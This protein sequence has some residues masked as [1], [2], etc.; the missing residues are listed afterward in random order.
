MA[1]AQ[2]SFDRL[3]PLF[4]LNLTFGGGD[5]LLTDVPATD[6]A[7]ET[8]EREEFVDERLL[9]VLLWFSGN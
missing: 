4:Q 6:P 9:L 1:A 3:L 2:F 7:K 8:V 5:R